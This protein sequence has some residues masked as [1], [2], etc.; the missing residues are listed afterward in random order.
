MELKMA[1]EIFTLKIDGKWV[2]KPSLD[3]WIASVVMVAGKLERNF[4]RNEGGSFARELFI[5]GRYYEVGVKRAS[6]EQGPRHIGRCDS[7]YCERVI[8][9]AADLNEVPTPGRQKIVASAQD[10]VRDQ[11]LAQLEVE[12]YEARA[13]IER[14][15]YKATLSAPLDSVA[16]AA[17]QAFVSRLIADTEQLVI[18]ANGKTR[19]AQKRADAA[20]KKAEI[21]SI[22]AASIRNFQNRIRRILKKEELELPEM[23]ATEFFALRDIARDPTIDHGGL[24]TSV[25]NII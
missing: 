6:G 13:L 14:E 20:E 12:L 19:D 22:Q 24:K 5:L 3:T 10:S 16:E 11:R 17:R 4:L 15:S 8:F 9:T 1:K 21:L 7:I 18:S 23:L 2:L 25:I